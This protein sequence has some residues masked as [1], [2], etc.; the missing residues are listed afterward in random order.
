MSFFP[1]LEDFQG[2]LT[3]GCGVGGAA[4]LVLF[5]LGSFLVG[6]KVTEKFI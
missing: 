1:F 6:F 5:T 2:C 4:C 3:L